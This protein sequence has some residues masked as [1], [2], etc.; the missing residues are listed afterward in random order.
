MRLPS[1]RPGPHLGRPPSRVNSPRGQGDKVT[2]TLKPVNFMDAVK[3]K[4]I[5]TDNLKDEEVP[6]ILGMI[7]PYITGFAGLKADDGSD[8]TLD[9]LFSA[10]CF[11]ALLFD[12]LTEWV[13]KGAPQNPLSPGASQGESRPG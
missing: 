2:L 7:K 5:D 3:F 9:E 6:A 4:N 13:S 10:F 8:V 11:S 1:R 12:M